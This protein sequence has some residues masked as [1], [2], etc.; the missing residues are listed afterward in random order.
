MRQQFTTMTARL[1]RM[2]SKAQPIIEH[3]WKFRPEISHGFYFVKRSATGNLPVYFE[4]GRHPN[5]LPI[6]TIRNV[7]GNAQGLLYDICKA[8]PQIKPDRAKVN[9]NTNTIVIKGDVYEQV[10]HV[11]Q[12]AF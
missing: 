4:S 7:S 1:G 12:T 2:P 10:L 3:S 8:I 6:V 11:L 9:S 5:S